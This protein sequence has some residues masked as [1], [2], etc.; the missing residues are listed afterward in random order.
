MQHRCA[1]LSVNRAHG[2]PADSSPVA[3]Q[4]SSAQPARPRSW[5]QSC[6]GR[7]GRTRGLRRKPTLAGG[8]PSPGVLRNKRR[9]ES[10]PRRLVQRLAGV[11]RTWLRRRQRHGSLS[12]L[13]RA[14]E[15]AGARAAVALIRAAVLSSRHA[16][17]GAARRM[18]ST[19]GR[20][21]DTVAVMPF[22]LADERRS[23]SAHSCIF[24]NIERFRAAGSARCPGRRC[25]RQCECAAPRPP[26][27][28]CACVA[29]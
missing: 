28:R 24:Y 2:T 12:T 15:C 16:T 14:G 20:A 7:P 17:R 18:V 21:N 22:R 3:H 23:N 4:Q 11:M 6:L 10:A 8:G 25:C 27:R 13:W 29:G 19:A 9:H 5:R 26:G 1:H